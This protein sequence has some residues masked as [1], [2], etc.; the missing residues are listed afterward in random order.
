[1]DRPF[2]LYHIF[3]YYVI[4]SKAKN[5]DLDRRL[6]SSEQDFPGCVN[7]II[8]NKLFSSQMPVFQG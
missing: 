4:L 8:L 7:I 1:M 6:I 3:C 5:L 2:C